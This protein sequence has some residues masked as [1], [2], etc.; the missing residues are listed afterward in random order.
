LAIH[1]C[2]NWR[3]RVPLWCICSLA[4]SAFRVPCSTVSDDESPHA[5]LPADALE[6]AILMQSLAGGFHSAAPLRFTGMVPSSR[7]A[8]T[9]PGLPHLLSHTFS[10][11]MHWRTVSRLSSL[12]IWFTSLRVWPKGISNEATHF[13]RAKWSRAVRL[14][15]ARGHEI[16][17]F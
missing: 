5:P 16:S 12:Q 14:R 3:F 8:S 1:I 2:W 4:I 7:T 15:R 6:G 13:R 11:H 17:R 10:I 9:W